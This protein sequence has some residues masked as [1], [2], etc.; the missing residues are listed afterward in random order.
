MGNAIRKRPTFFSAIRSAPF[1]SN[2]GF[3]LLLAA[4]CL[5]PV[6]VGCD[7]KT[8]IAP[9]EFAREDEFE[10]VHFVVLWP[11]L[12]GLSIAI[13]LAT[14]ACM[15]PKRLGRWLL[16]VPLTFQL[17]FLVTAIFAVAVSDEKE[18]TFSLFVLLFPSVVFLC[19]TVYS[20]YRHD[21]FRA[22]IRSI[23]GMCMLATIGVYAGTVAMLAS[24]FLYGFY[25]AMAA[26]SGMLFSSW[27]LYS[28]GEHCLSDRELPYRTMQF[29]IRAL[30]IWTLFVALLIAGYQVV[31]QYDEQEP[32]VTY[33]TTVEEDTSVPASAQAETPSQ[34]P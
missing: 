7:E 9:I 21:L 11:Y 15:R 17:A 5:M 18:R 26:A 2:L 29:G 8:R 23:S 14:V 34:D 31:L 13:L 19:Y 12:F 33:N 16:P 32:V 10:M 6:A 4:T 1:V 28:R 30:L 22:A 25:V 20:L 3:S 24:R 27:L